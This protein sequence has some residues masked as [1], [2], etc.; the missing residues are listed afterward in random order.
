MKRLLLSLFLAPALF[1][2]WIVNDPVNT[3][4]STAIQAGQQ[5]NHIETLRQWAEQLNRLNQQLRQLEEAVTLQRRIR[6]VLGDPVQA[7]TE[8][9]LRDLGA[10]E[11][12]RTYGETLRA[13]QRLADASQSLRRTAEGLYRSLDGPTSLRRDFTRDESLYRRYGAVERQADNLAQVQDETG[14]RLATLQMDLAQTLMQLRGASTAAEVD[15]LNVKVSALNGQIALLV[16]Q[17]RDESD[18]LVAQQIL[19]ANQSEKERQDFLEKQI[20]EEQDSLRVAGE[21][22]RSIRLTPTNYT[23]R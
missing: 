7:G 20:A 3:A 12:S 19:N 5:A 13:I 11:L 9:V 14:E 15:K 16:A 2:Q 1:G 17:R 6:D 8:L 10:E 4:V 22:Q 18:K 23:E 21:W